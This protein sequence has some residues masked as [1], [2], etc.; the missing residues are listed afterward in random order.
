MKISELKMCPICKNY[1]K[2]EFL[3]YFRGTKCYCGDC[4]SYLGKHNELS[5]KA[6]KALNQP[7]VQ[8]K[9]C[10]HKVDFQGR[11]MCSINAKFICGEW[12][13]LTAT[14]NEN[15]CIYGCRH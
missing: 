11:V 13:G 2:P 1:G 5:K 8:C 4:D 6:E 3:T 9:K 10:I 12:R 7:L 15:S 14:H